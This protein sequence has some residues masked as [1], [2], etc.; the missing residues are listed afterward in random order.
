MCQSSVQPAAARPDRAAQ[1]VANL[2][3]GVT[4]TWCQVTPP[5]WISSVGPLSV[6]GGR[7]YHQRRT[8][9]L[10]GL[11]QPE[12]S[13]KSA[14]SARPRR[15]VNPEEIRRSAPGLSRRARCQGEPP[16]RNCSSSSSS[17]GITPTRTG[18]LSFRNDRRLEIAQVSG[19][20]HL[21][22]SDQAEWDKR[23]AAIRHH[24][25]VL[26]GLD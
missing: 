20:K 9:R 18:W 3:P 8:H 17:A 10:A 23:T 2:N 7:S 12:P 24:Y 11:A 1:L 16:W 4:S 15:Q 25:R 6:V 22:A 19:K 26:V 21:S 5:Q 13:V 14:G